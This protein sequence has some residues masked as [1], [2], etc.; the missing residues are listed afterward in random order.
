MWIVKTPIGVCLKQRYFEFE[1]SIAF[2][3]TSATD[4]MWTR[5]DLRI[6]KGEKDVTNEIM[7][8]HEKLGGIPD[9][10][11]WNPNIPELTS[12]LKT[13]DFMKGANNDS[14]E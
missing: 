2:E 7:D 11:L 3:G 12:L 13:L 5:A 1:I 8:Q 4:E 10:I 14:Q 9:D 6:Y